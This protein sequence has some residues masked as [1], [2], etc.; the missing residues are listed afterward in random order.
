MHRLWTNIITTI[1]LTGCSTFS[2]PWL[3]NMSEYDAYVGIN[4]DKKEQLRLLTREEGL[5]DIGKKIELVYVDRSHIGADPL[6]FNTRNV[7]RGD[8]DRIIFVFKDQRLYLVPSEK[9][10]LLKTTEPSIL[11]IDRVLPLH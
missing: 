9:G 4:T 10:D 3:I 5:S 11:A 6:E 2:G 8:I 7:R 1:F